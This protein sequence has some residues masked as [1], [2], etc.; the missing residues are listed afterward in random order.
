MT[1]HPAL[2]ATTTPGPFGQPVRRIEDPAL[3]TGQGRY[4]DDIHF[5]DML[6]AAFVRSPFSHALIKGI[7]VSAAAAQEGV[8]A[9]LTMDDLAQHLTSDRLSVGMPSKAYLQLRDRPV[10][11]R[12][13]VCHVGEPVAVVIADDRYIA[14]DAAALV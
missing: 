12:T 5:P 2:D 9:V 11:A 10:L 3:L 13:E 14:E 8:R 7:D 1:T 6:Q 4:A